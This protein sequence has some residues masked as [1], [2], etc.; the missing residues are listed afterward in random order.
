MKAKTEHR[1]A[2][3]SRAVEILKS[4]PSVE[5]E[6][7]VFPGGRKGG[8]L[9]NMAMLELLRDMRPGKTVHGMRSTFRDWVSDAT[10][11]SPE[12][13]E[14]ALA[15][16]IKNQTE[17][18]Y[19]RGDLLERRREMMEGW[20]TYLSHQKTGKVVAIHGGAA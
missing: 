14:M 11:Y 8:P 6:D 7:W 12:L 18:A 3:S 9:S 4:L 16:T 2:L 5:G 19:R 15:H 13:A 1:V 17:A 10:N 20:N